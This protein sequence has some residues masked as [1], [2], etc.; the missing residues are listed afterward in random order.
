[1]DITKYRFVV[2]TISVHYILYLT[3]A[4]CKGCNRESIRYGGVGRV[5]VTCIESLVQ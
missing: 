2:F 1:M 5:V 3:V 4:E